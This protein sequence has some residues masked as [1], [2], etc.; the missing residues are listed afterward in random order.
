MTQADHRFD[1]AQPVVFIRNGAVFANSRD[2]AGFFEKEVK[3]VHE[4]IRSL[5]KKAPADL[6]PIFRPF[7]IKDLTGESV[8]HFEMTRDGF[9]L[10]AMGFT[11]PRALRW[12]L[13]YIEAF[14]QMEGALRDAEHMR[15]ARANED[16]PL[17]SDYWLTLVREARLTH[18]RAAAAKLWR[19]SPLHQVPS[20]MTG[21]LDPAGPDAMCVEFLQECCEVTGHRGSFVRSRVL[22]DALS[23]YAVERGHAWP[24]DRSMSNALRRVAA[25]YCDPETGRRM[26]PAKRSDAG[27]LGVRL[28]GR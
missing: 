24:G 14:N 21:D 11:G 2:V 20:G 26:H 7:K 28:R 18:G 6:E 1:N 3:H 22:I 27:Y 15:Q 16:P 10:L 23:R 19:E 8:S 4:A 9:T 12:K 25:T 17:S 5:I 13:R